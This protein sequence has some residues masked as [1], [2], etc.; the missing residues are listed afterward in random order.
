[1]SDL[2]IQKLTEIR[3]N[4][5]AKTKAIAKQLHRMSTY[6]IA[7]PT[8]IPQQNSCKIQHTN[9]RVDLGPNFGGSDPDDALGHFYQIEGSSD[10]PPPP[11]PAAAGPKL[12]M[13]TGTDPS[14][15]TNRDTPGTKKLSRP[16][17]KTSLKGDAGTGTPGLAPPQKKQGVTGKDLK[18]TTTTTTT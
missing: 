16:V 13:R 10:Q 11:P 17:S 18:T 3:N 1:M 6:R 15:A 14:R 8:L 4:S 2:D 7:Y 12:A 9:I 5:R